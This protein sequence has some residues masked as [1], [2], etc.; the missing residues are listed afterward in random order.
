MNY[1]VAFSEAAFNDILEAT[2]WYNRIQFGVGDEFVSELE[3]SIAFI[4]ENPFAKAE[5]SK[6]YRI[7]LLR[8]F[9]FKIIYQFI[10]MIL[11]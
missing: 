8:R 5:K 1:T 2:L 9:P 6:R 3:F 11:S 10:Q 4:R 7:A